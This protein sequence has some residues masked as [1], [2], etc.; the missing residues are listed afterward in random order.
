MCFILFYSTSF[1]LIASTWSQLEGKTRLV[2]F[3]AWLV[4]R[5]MIGWDLAVCR[6]LGGSFSYLGGWGRGLANL[7]NNFVFTAFAYKNK[8]FLKY[9]HIIYLNNYLWR[10]TKIFKILRKC[11]FQYH[12]Y[13][14]VEKCFD[15]KHIET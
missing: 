14:S 4:K 13:N 10:F 11:S 5:S 3:Y 9:I 6:Y 7:E 8:L 2:I 1:R 15:W 12:L